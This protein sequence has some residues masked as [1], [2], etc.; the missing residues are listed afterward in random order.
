MYRKMQQKLIRLKA[1]FCIPYN[2]TAGNV[3]MVD[4][5]VLL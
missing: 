2:Y 5:F 3:H 1:C 4:I